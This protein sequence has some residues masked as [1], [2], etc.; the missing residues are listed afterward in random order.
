MFYRLTVAHVICGL[1]M[2]FGVFVYYLPDCG[3]A[4][5]AAYLP[6]KF[7]ESIARKPLSK[8]ARFC[9]KTVGLVVS[10]AGLYLFCVYGM[11]DKT[12]L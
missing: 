3:L 10:L 1:V 5:I 9:F 6:T 11:N 8:S 2:G 12:Y 4:A 7:F